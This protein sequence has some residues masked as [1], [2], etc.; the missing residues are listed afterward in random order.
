MHS[1]LSEYNA[2][3]PHQNLG[4]IKNFWEKNNQPNNKTQ[5]QQQQKAKQNNV[6]PTRSEIGEWL[7]A[8]FPLKFTAHYNKAHATAHACTMVKFWL[9][10]SKW[11]MPQL[12]T[13]GLWICSTQQQLQVKE[14]PIHFIEVKALQTK[15]QD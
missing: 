15:N 3:L 14:K 8:G 9:L 6:T 11:Q 5:Q 13:L 10:D 1:F 12:P 7:T 4:T 2:T